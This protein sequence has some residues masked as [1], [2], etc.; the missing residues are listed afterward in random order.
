MKVTSLTEWLFYQLIKRDQS[1]V[2][3]SSKVIIP[4]TVVFR[5]SSPYFLYFSHQDR[6][7]R[8]S[9]DAISMEKVK[10]YLKSKSQHLEIVA[11]FLQ[12]EAKTS[13]L[14]ESILLE[15]LKKEDLRMHKVFI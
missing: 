6:I 3:I 1:G 9:K 10:N 13:E 14:S 11:Q 2:F 5:Y 12:V 8:I 4:R 15:Y 7:R